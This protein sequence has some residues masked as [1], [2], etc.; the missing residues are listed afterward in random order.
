MYEPLV[1]RHLP[2]TIGSVS[3]ALITFAGACAS[4]APAVAVTPQMPEPVP[5]TALPGPVL[6]VTPLPADPVL[7]LIAAS[8][9]H[10][11]A[12]QRE[13]QLGHVEAAKQE[14]DKAVTVLLESPYGGRAEPRVREHFDRLIDRIST[15]E[16]KALAEGDGFTEKKSE[17]ASIDE[18]LALS[19]DA[20]ADASA[21]TERSRQGRPRDRRARYSD[22]AQPESAVVHLAV[23]GTPS[24]LPAGR[25]AARQPVSPDDPGRSAG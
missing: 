4:K 18:L 13:L 17:P 23:P 12:G 16:V 6:P 3:L 24:R 19:A 7:A 2:V 8:D 25:H 22:S 1:R 15:Y 21:G 10:F 9:S 20:D 11:K 14:F 5:V